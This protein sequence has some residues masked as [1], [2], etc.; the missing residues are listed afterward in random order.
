MFNEGLNVV[1][2]GENKLKCQ[3]KLTCNITQ[4]YCLST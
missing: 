1:F 3:N 2:L 4:P